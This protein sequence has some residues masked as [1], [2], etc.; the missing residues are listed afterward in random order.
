MT[1]TNITK[2]Q[3]DTLVRLEGTGVVHA[4]T[5]GY[6]QSDLDAL[7]TAGLCKFLGNGEYLC[8]STGRHLVSAYRQKPDEFR[9]VEEA[10]VE[11]EQPKKAQRRKKA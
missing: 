7:F 4:A 9:F 11:D 6:E 2:S 5:N 10:A 8:N 3:M 1:E